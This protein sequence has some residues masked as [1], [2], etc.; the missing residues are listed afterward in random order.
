MEE[1]LR[2]LN[3]LV[4]QGKIHYFGIS[5]APA[6]V[7][8]RANTLSELRGWNSF[9]GLQVE[10]SLIRRTI[11]R[12]LLPMAKFYDMAV[13]TWGPLSGGIL[14]GKYNKESI[15]DVRYKE[16]PWADAYRTPANLDT[17]QAVVELAQ[18]IDR[19]PAQVALRWVYQQQ[20]R[21]NIIPILGARKVTQLQDNLSVLDFELGQEHMDRLN[22]IT[23][24]EL[25][26]PHDFL[27]TV[28]GVIFGDEHERIKN[29]RDYRA[30]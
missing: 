1:V 28:P 4:S 13:T 17:A 3:D 29:H 25:G 11:E 6:W 16:G 8:S 15:G 26:F 19:S 22:A 24:I 5:D 21:A 20:Q 2:G 12:D 10:Y 14:T 18:E 23:K 7:V 27:N 9:L 30:L